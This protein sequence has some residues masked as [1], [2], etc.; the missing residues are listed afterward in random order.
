MKSVSFSSAKPKL[1]TH[2][3]EGETESQ[4]LPLQVGAVTA[5]PLAGA[6]HASSTLCCWAVIPLWV[7]LAPEML[8]KLILT[9]FW[10]WRTFPFICFCGQLYTR[11]SIQQLPWKLLIPLHQPARVEVCLCDGS[12]WDVNRD[13][14]KWRKWWNC[15]WNP[16]Y[17]KLITCEAIT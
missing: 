1:L 13:S 4:L 11:F 6:G 16:I 3:A 2:Q 5:G 7:N 14:T 10:F 8:H 17:G 9:H 15:G 12:Y